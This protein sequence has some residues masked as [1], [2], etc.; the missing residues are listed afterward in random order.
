[1]KNHLESF[2]NYIKVEKNLSENTAINYQSDLTQ[3]FTKCKIEDVEELTKSNIRLYLVKIADLSAKTRKRKLA[4]IRSFMAFLKE[5]NI[6][7][8]NYA[9]DIKTPKVPKTVPRVMTQNETATILDSVDNAQDKAILETL[10]GIGC[11]IS[12]LINMKI[13]DINFEER[14]VLIRG[15]GDKERLLP[16]NNTALRCIKEH[17]ETRGF[18][19]PYVFGSKVNP[20]QPMSARNARDRVYKYTDGK[21][22]PHKF[23][24]SFA[25]HLLSNDADIRVIQELLGHADISTTTIYT[26]VANEQMSRAYRHAHPRG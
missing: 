13:T 12:E 2:I 7:S 21:I 22:S 15:K 6:I 1:M 19:S 10:Y 8:D 9:L 23:R 16:I 20:S 26:S 17:L 18:Y 11:R 3:F 4:S 25:T 5:E 24:H 14:T